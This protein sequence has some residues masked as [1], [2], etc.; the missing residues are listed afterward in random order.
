MGSPFL[1]YDFKSC[2]LAVRLLTSRLRGRLAIVHILNEWSLSIELR[3]S[4]PYL[5]SSE[6]TVEGTGSKES[7]GKEDPVE[8]D[9]SLIM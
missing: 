2:S 3:F 9:T 5:L 8:L 6:T 1:Q 7:A 4:C